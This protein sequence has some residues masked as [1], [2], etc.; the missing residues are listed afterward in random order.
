MVAKFVFKF[1]VNTTPGILLSIQ[2]QSDECFKHSVCNM[3]H[4]VLEFGVSRWWKANE[5]HCT[6]Q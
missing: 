2:S 1:S 6:I 5:N 4:C 3:N